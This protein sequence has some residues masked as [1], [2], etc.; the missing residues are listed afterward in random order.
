[1]KESH[2]KN[3][4]VSTKLLLSQLPL[5][6]KFPNLV[7]NQSLDTFVLFC[8]LVSK[9]SNLLKACMLMKSLEMKVKLAEK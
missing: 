3:G 6:Y 7:S 5:N 8:Y 2:R 4:G 9:L 1:M